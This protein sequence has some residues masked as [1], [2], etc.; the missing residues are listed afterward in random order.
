M[1]FTLAAKSPGHRMT[2]ETY[3]A[4]QE[5]LPRLQDPELQ[6]NL[7]DELEEIQLANPQLA[8]KIK[9]LAGSGFFQTSPVAKSDTGPD[10]GRETLENHSPT[11][12]REP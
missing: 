7:H 8:L 10:D 3:E 11:Q 6:R 5:I 4:M 9:A 12:F 2:K 1:L